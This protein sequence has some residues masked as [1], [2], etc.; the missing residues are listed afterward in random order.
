MRTNSIEQANMMKSNVDYFLT[1]PEKREF[2]VASQ[3]KAYLKKKSPNML[4]GWQKRLF[5]IR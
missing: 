2:A 5:V 1:E 3:L 4:V